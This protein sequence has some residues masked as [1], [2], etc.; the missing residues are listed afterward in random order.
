MK[1][2]YPPQWLIR[3]FRWFCAPELMPFIEGDLIEIYQQHLKDKGRW[4]ANWLFLGEIIKLLRPSLMRSL[5]GNTRLNYYGIIKH[6]FLVTVRGFKKEKS[7]VSINLLGLTLSLCVSLLMWHYVR[8][9]KSVDGHHHNSSNKYR[10][11]YSYL[12]DGELITKSNHA[13]YAMGPMVSSTLA[14]FENMVRVR[15]LFTDELVAISNDEKQFSSRSVYYV[16]ATFLDFFNYPLE[17]GTSSEALSSP[18]NIV[19]THESAHKFFGDTDPMG[20]PLHVSGGSLTGDFIVSGVLAEEE[21]GTHLDFDYL[22]PIEFMLSHYG[23]YVR[24]D[25]WFWDNFFT[26]VELSE[27]VD[28]GNLSIRMDTLINQ[29]LADNLKATNQTIQTGFQPIADIY[30]D[31]FIAGDGGL[32]KGSPTDLTI[33]SIAAIF[34]L[35]IAAINY[36]NLASGRAITKR[37]EVSLKKVI[38]AS[39]RQLIGQFVFESFIF[40]VIALILGLFLFYFL[41]PSFNS[42]VRI[43]S[44]FHLIFDLKFCGMLLAGVGLASLFIGF[45][46]AFISVKTGQLALSKSNVQSSGR[47]KGNWLK[48]SLLI[49][50]FMI[51]IMLVAG[52]WLVYQQIHFM[53]NH[54]LGISMEQLLI[55]NGPIAVLEEG[56][57]VMKMKQETLRN[58]LLTYPSIEAISGTSNVPGTGEIWYGGVRKLGDPREK[59]VLTQAILVD[60]A[61]TDAYAF[62][63]L[64]G[65]PFHKNMADYEAV[66]INESALKAFGF[67][68][69]QEALKHS[70]VMENMDT[71]K[72]HGVVKDV[73]WNSLQEPIHPVIFGINDYPRFYTF[74]IATENLSTTLETIETTYRKLYPKDAYHSFFLDDDFNQHYESEQRF[75]LL[76]GLLAGIAIL[77]SSLGLFALIA[78]S[79]SRKVKEIGIRKALGAT[80]SQLFQ[81]ISKE[82]FYVFMIALVLAIPIIYIAANRWLE[83]YAF[84]VGIR[85][86]LFIIPATLV[87][88]ITF[89]MVTKKILSSV[90]TS[91]VEQLRNE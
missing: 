33:F 59:E 17:K 72:I 77:I 61:F 43:D 7:Y 47:M 24:N 4:R 31:P 88:L 28:A 87:A 5:E 62:E 80:A 27:N 3:F 90:H 9:E 57:D 38:G 36:V 75:G 65:G 18:N 89:L 78:F 91:P 41:I 70:V 15:P 1:I 51:A 35:I 30:L 6:F 42:I 71:L 76:F 81:F 67:Q 45:Y 40:N 13:T 20:Q 56:R 34:L 63:F 52:T 84:S 58:E 50:Q 83:S 86:D 53:K 85:L 21:F 11:N 8:H 10:I 39:K 60:A 54:Q 66:I 26:Y 32:K 48:K 79:L 25:G 19:L 49:F 16:E 23:L 82:Y 68:A 73:H 69:P 46:L 29:R 2:S 37:L 14:G 12:K 44:S 64:G 74:K 55:V 22:I